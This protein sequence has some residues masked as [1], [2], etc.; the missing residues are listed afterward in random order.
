MSSTAV[1]EPLR[2]S[3]SIDSYC[4]VIH[5]RSEKWE[6]SFFE[7]VW[8]I[9]IVWDEEVDSSEKRCASVT[10]AFRTVMVMRWSNQVRI[11]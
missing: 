10:Y 5:H 2:L 6:G 4:I 9:W 3:L 7:N 8:V 1:P 11:S